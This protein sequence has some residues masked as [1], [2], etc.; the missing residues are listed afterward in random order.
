MAAL[1]AQ[2]GSS[3][4][5]GDTGIEG[6]RRDASI[7]TRDAQ[8]YAARDTSWAGTL[9]G[10]AT[11]GNTPWTLK[12]TTAANAQAAYSTNRALAQAAHDAALLSAMNDWRESSSGSYLK[13]LVSSSRAE[14]DFKSSVAGFW[15]DWNMATE[16][17]DRG[18]PTGFLGSVTDSVM[19]LM[20]PFDTD[21]IARSLTKETKADTTNGPQRPEPSDIHVVYSIYGIVSEHTPE[22]WEVI[23]EY[24]RKGRTW[25]EWMMGG[26]RKRMDAAG[27][28]TSF[29]KLEE[30]VPPAKVLP[31]PT[32]PSPPPAVP[33]PSPEIPMQAPTSEPVASSATD[34][35]DVWAN[36]QIPV[37]TDFL[38]GVVRHTTGDE[39]LLTTSS[40]GLIV[41]TV[42]VSAITVGSLYIAPAYCASVPTYIVYGALASSI[43]YL[44]INALGNAI[45]DAHSDSTIYGAA[46]SAIFGGLLSM[47]GRLFRGGCFVSDTPV[48]VSELPSLVE[49]RNS[50]DSTRSWSGEFGRSGTLVQRK[51]PIE[52]LSIGSRVPTKN[53]NRWEVAPQAEPDQATWSKLSITVQRSDG[54]VIDAELIRPRSWME[55]YD[56]RA[57]RTIRLNLPELEVSGVAT[58]T[59]LSSCPPIA[60]GEGSVISGRFMTRQVDEVTSVEIL[61]ADGATE[62][63]T[64]TSIHPV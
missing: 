34:P 8:Y 10:S 9:S 17:N 37:V 28:K 58:I 42:G 52:S 4:S 30:D 35:L 46:E 12:A 26:E 61:G 25:E 23:R 50:Y 20:N 44:A 16:G 14:N 62:T 21:S 38:A 45:N 18:A 7:S 56:L 53:P 55:A 2:Y 63:I 39:F 32:V 27:F 5:N 49:L 13:S 1:D 22:E 40:E 54:G 60:T 43:Q 19:G 48:T 3:S 59:A 51:V 57:G 15:A 47:F 64:G 6:A 29:R 36:L 24:Q 41:Y 31:T 33:M 11:I